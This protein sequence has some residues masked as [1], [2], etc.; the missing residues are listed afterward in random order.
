[1]HIDWYT[2]VSI[3]VVACVVGGIRRWFRQNAEAYTRDVL[4]KR[5]GSDRE[6]ERY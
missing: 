3:I 4:R 2:V 6:K 1:M 5:Y